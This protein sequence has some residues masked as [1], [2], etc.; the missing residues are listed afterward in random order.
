MSNTSLQVQ[1]KLLRW[2]GYK[3]TDIYNM[4]TH[5]TNTRAG[6]KDYKKTASKKLRT[7]LSSVEIRRGVLLQMGTL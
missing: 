1:E 5:T 3:D 4:H 6:S 2:K 7:K